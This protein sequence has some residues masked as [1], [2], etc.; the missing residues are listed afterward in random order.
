MK[1]VKIAIISDIHA[2]LE[3][4]YSFIKYIDKEQIGVVLNLGDF[5]SNGPNPC[6]VFDTI[7]SDKRFINIR[8]YDENSIFNETEIDEGIGQGRWLKEKLGAARLNQLKDISSTQEVEIEGVKMILCHHNGWSSVEQLTAHSKELKYEKYNFLMCGGTHQQEL[9]TGR[10]KYPKIKVIDPGTL[11]RREDKKAYF[12]TIVLTDEEPSIRF[13]CINIERNILKD[14]KIDAIE[15]F[16]GKKKDNKEEFKKEYIY[17]KGHK[18]INNEKQYLEDK[19][20]D[21]I[22]EIGIANCKYIS[23]C[24]WNNEKQIIREILY[25]LKCRQMKSSNTE[26]QEWYI[27]EVTKEVAELL[28]NK[29][30]LL[31]GRLKWF[32]VSFFEGYQD[33]SPKYSIFNYGKKGFLKQIPEKEFKE[34][35]EL[36]EK[37]NLAY[38]LPK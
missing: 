38:T 33:V 12:A 24:C 28:R 34:L 4:L 31:S 3:A 26:G 30:N 7:M 11:G 36:L 22:I 37:Y 20:I 29:R 14:I 32:E 35:I 21:K 15:A 5:I 27:G 23:I 19:V 2:N 16:I 18:E 13:Q 9:S 25:Y 8:G 17:I 1:S 10:G 6:E